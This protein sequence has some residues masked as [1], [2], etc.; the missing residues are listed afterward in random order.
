MRSASRQSAI[1]V[2]TLKSPDSKVWERFRL[3]NSPISSVNAPRIAEER[4]VDITVGTAP[5]SVSHRS[6]LEVKVIAADGT[7]STVTGA[8]TGLERVE[9]IVR[10]NGRGVD[11]RSEGR[12][13]FLTYKDQP[14]ALGKVGVALGQAGINIEAAA[15]SPE[16]DGDNAILILRVSQEVPEDLVESIVDEIDANRALQLVLN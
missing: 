2:L 13:L 14:G 11:M 1:W 12:N 3:M 9:K 6:V 5:E 7:S 10:I 8:L 15:L 16:A 4:G